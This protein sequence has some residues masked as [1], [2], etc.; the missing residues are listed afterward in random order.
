MN[1]TTVNNTTQTLYP[2]YHTLILV[3]PGKQLHFKTKE[4]QEV[5]H[6]DKLIN[7]I[8]KVMDIQY[9][10]HCTDNQ[11]RLITIYG[12]GDTL[13]H[14]VASKTLQKQLIKRKD[15]QN[16]IKTGVHCVKQLTI[17]INKVMH[18]ITANLI[19]E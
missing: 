18:Y 4:E 7:V 3:I 17:L 13:I 2:T 11:Y 14:I 15:Q 10:T 6:Y 16:S 8:M 12:A 19:N 9:I 1:G 5:K